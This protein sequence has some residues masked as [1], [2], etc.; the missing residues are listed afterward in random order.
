MEVKNN[1]NYNNNKK[2]IIKKTY[3]HT[4]MPSNI[5]IEIESKNTKMTYYELIHRLKYNML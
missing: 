4:Y 3:T 1:N 5:Y 2:I